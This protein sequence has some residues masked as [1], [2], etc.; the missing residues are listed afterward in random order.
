MGGFQNFEDIQ[1]WQ[2]AMDLFTRLHGLLQGSQSHGYFWLRDQILKASLSICNNI[3]EGFGRGS[4]QEFAR[5]LTY[6]KGSAVEVLS[7]LKACERIGF[8]PQATT[9]ELEGLTQRCIQVI[10]KLQ[11]YLDPTRTRE[12]DHAYDA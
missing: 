11:A 8:L 7:C 5:F 3:A 1:A 9:I 6:S 4:D 2:I 10:S 12:A